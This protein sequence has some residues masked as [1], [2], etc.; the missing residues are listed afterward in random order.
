MT[1]GTPPI[2]RL[3]FGDDG[4]PGA[5][6]AWL[7][8]N[9]HP[10][11]GWRIEAWTGSSELPSPSSWGTPPLVEAWTPPWGRPYLGDARAVA[12][13]H[14]HSDADP[15]L[16]LG[17]QAGVDL[18]VVGV[19]GHDLGSMWSGSTTGWLLRHPPAPLAIARSAASVQRVVWCADGSVHAQRAV[20]AF[21]ALPLAEGTHVTGLVVDDHRVDVDVTAAAAQAFL[22]TR[23]VESSVERVEGKPTRSILEHLVANDAELVVLGTRGLTGW[24]RLRV[25]STAGAVVQ[26]A[27][28]NTLLAC[29]DQPATEGEPRKGDPLASR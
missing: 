19:G 28:C 20:D 26:H 11:P 14:F 10:W 15:R 8:I 24:R 25:G 6:V 12:V 23:D 29:V 27:R 2:R 21:L 7:W 4:C 3:V 17:E 5:D 22:E 13:E 1:P 16:V 18:I 9:N